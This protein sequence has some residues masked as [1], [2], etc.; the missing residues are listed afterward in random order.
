[1]PV[2]FSCK[3]CR[4]D[5]LR[6]SGMMT[7]EPFR[8]KPL[9]DVSSFSCTR[10]YRQFWVLIYVWQVTNCAWT[11]RLWTTRGSS[12]FP[13]VLYPTWCHWWQCDHHDILKGISSLCIIQKSLERASWSWLLL[14]GL[15]LVVASYIWRQRSIFEDQ[16]VKQLNSWAWSSSE[17][18]DQFV[19]CRSS[20]VGSG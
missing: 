19:L 2:C 3:S 6:V 7:L 12:Q 1:M 15:Y 9:S 18:Y 17:P 13:Y 8:S 5:S 20:C 11:C 14:P 16:G 4:N 10:I